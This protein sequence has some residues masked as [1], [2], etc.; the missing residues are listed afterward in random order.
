[1]NLP[2]DYE[3]T[4]AGPTDRDDDSDVDMAGPTDIDDDDDN[5]DDGHDQHPGQAQIIV[6]SGVA[7]V[8]D[9][10]VATT[11]PCDPPVTQE[12]DIRLVEGDL[13][14]NVNVSLSEGGAKEHGEGE[15]GD[16]SKDKTPIQAESSRVAHNMGTNIR[17]CLPLNKT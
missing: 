1:L 3:D 11:I 15:T 2:E 14:E 5:N 10:D 7:N 16:K 9:A 6:E 8:S 12:V 13:V 4:V 17:C